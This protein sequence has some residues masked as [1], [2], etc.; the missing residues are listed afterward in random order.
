MNKDWGS[1]DCCSS[2]NI[3]ERKLEK[4]SPDPAIPEGPPQATMTD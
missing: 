4:E 1:D 3:E 2:R